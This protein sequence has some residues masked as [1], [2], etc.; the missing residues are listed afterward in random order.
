MSN[1]QDIY[2]ASSKNHPF[3]LNK[4]NYVPWSSRLFC[5]TNSKPNGKL[6]YNFIMNSPYVRRMIPKLGDPDRKVLVAETFHE[7]TADELTEKE[8]KQIEAMIKPF[9]LF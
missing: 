7:Q 5:Y 2:A 9:G 6:I 1:Q 8:V 3:V 4:N